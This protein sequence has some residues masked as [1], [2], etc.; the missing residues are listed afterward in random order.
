MF[1]P[2]QGPRP[3]PLHLL[4]QAGTLLGSLTAL[5][6]WRHGLPF[7]KDAPNAKRQSEL[8]VVLEQL[9]P[10]EWVHF[11]QA[12]TAEAARRHRT[13][14]DGVT[15][16]R[17]NP[18]RRP[19]EHY[20]VIWQ[21]GTTRLLDC[22]LPGQTGPAA[23]LVP[24]LINRSYILDLTPRNSVV[25]GLA[26]RQV[27]PFLLDWG[28]PGPEEQDFT[29]TDYMT[30]RLEPALAVL[31]A[32]TGE[33][34]SLLGYCMG[35]LLALALAQ[36]QPAQVAGLVLL[37]T[38]WDFHCGFEVQRAFLAPLWSN[39]QQL[40][41][42]H[43]GL[44]VDVLQTLFT[45]FDPDLTARKF[46]YFSRLPPRSVAARD[47]VLLEDWVND[48]VPLVRDVARECLEDWYLNN[49]PAQH[50]W[51][52]D[53]RAVV[54]QEITC[55]SLVMVPER[56]RIVTPASALALAGCLPHSTLRQVSGG[57]VGMLLSRRVG[58]LVHAPMALSIKKWTRH[59]TEKS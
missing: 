18:A 41:A 8:A 9:N 43:N 37:A 57:H 58:S 33:P 15:A 5:P 52:I 32:L 30:K 21:Q 55:P 45:T 14:V 54:P 27:A 26:R 25:R 59:A 48:G 29:L 35:G 38:P 28:A 44:P 42:T 3:L 53:G 2:R 46:S 1:P 56:D 39:L 49:A 17:H 6:S 11:T 50:R 24:S 10:E 23:L 16:Y 12:V 4:I 31:T 13:F 40:I 34:A 19:T 22:R 47:F 51:C 36:R 20:P 7:W